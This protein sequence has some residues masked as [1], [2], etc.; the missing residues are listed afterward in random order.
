VICS[1]LKSIILFL[2]VLFLIN[3]ALVPEAF[4]IPFGALQLVTAI[5]GVV[6]IGLLNIKSAR[7]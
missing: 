2:S 6:S 4:L 7:Q 1:I 3:Y 5:T